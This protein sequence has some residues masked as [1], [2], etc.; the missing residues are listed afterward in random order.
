MVG[1]FAY[2]YPE[3]GTRPLTIKVKD[4][5]QARV[6]YSCDFVI[7][8]EL[9]DGRSLYIHFNKKQ[10][11]CSWQLMEEKTIRQKEEYLRKQGCWGIVR[12]R[13]LDYKNRQEN[14]NLKSRSVYRKT[15]NDVYNEYKRWKT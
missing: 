11:S 1:G 6:R 8:R 4:S 14:A 9:R 13:Y 10:N 15:I 2:D 5:M 7:K 12:D 3:K